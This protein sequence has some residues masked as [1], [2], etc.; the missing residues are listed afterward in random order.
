MNESE[1][2]ARQNDVENDFS[3]YFRDVAQSLPGA[4]FRYVLYPD[5]REDIE[6]MSPGCEAIWE[7]SWIDVRDDPA[8]LWAMIEPDDIHIMHGS[9]EL[10]LRTLDPWMARYHI[11]TPSGARK[12]LEGRGMP[13]R[14]Q[15]GA[16]VWT[17]IVLDVTAEEVAQTEIERTISLFNEIQ[18]QEEFTRFSRGLGHDFNNLLTIIAGNA[19]LLDDIELD[20]ASAQ[21]VREILS[22]ARR[23]ESLSRR[24]MR[25]TGGA[26]ALEP[27][28]ASLAIR[29]MQEL[30]RRSLPGEVAMDMR[31]AV[32]LPLVRVNRGQLDSAVLNLVFNARDAMPDGGRL[33]LSTRLE[34][35]AAATDGGF[36]APIHPGRYVVVSVQ[37]TGLG[38]S[39]DMVQRVFSPYVTTKTKG[40]EGGLGLSLVDSFAR[41]AGGAVRVDS[42]L[43]K[44]TT[45]SV[46][47]PALEALGGDPG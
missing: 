33:R 7:R 42:A 43:G 44:G 21:Y 40:S 36:S 12:C 15:D 39:G 31:L 3:A 37:D 34:E 46:F 8:A 35:V 20:A 24:L 17:S 38:M 6:Y 26:T 29:S 45:L 2:F 23:A 16:T 9:I 18:K 25:M 27:I 10:S 1:R 19:E 14:R 41:G 5:G 32:G 4:I 13:T 22:A 11:R 30:L 47:L 28:N